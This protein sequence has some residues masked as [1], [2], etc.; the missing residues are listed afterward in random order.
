MAATIAA[1]LPATGRPSTRR[2]QTFEDGKI[3]HAE[4]ARV[5]TGAGVGVGFGVGCG[6]GRGVGF[7]VGLGVGFGFVVAPGLP[8]GA[9]DGLPEAA[10][11]RDPPGVAEAAAVRALGTD[12][13]PVDWSVSV[14]I[15]APPRTARQAASANAA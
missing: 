1:E 8:A 12:R 10:A 11:D 6:V 14:P 15:A 7:G 3:G 13:S 5:A 2:F 4:S 9:T